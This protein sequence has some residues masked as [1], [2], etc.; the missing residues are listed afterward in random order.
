MAIVPE[1]LINKKFGRLLVKQ[2][3]KENGFVYC[4]CQCDCG[5][6]KKHIRYYGLRD[7][8]VQSCGCFQKEKVRNKMTKYDLQDLV[9]ETYGRLTIRKAYREGKKSLIYCDCICSC[10]NISDHIQ[11][12][13]LKNG[14]SKSCG[15]LHDEVSAERL[16]KQRKKYN[17]YEEHDGWMEGVCSDGK[18]FKF[19]TEDYERIKDFCWRIDTNDFVVAYNP[20]N[21]KIIFLHKFIMDCPDG[22]QVDHIYHNR[23]D[24]RK[25]MLRICTPQENMWNTRGRNDNSGG[26]KGVQH[27]QNGKWLAKIEGDSLG[28]FENF[29]DACAIYEAE[30]IKRHGR[31]SLYSEVK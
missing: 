17:Q 29:E 18:H 22:Y 8:V 12:S 25:S 3:Y 11:Y 14:T 4:D 1:E 10:G 2:A 19:D 9:G 6:Y 20:E 13:A 21:R 31:F 24:N 15:C 16:S 23:L 27:L 7:G 28:T 5:T 30:D 26:H